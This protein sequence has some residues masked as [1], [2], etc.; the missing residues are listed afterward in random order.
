MTHTSKYINAYLGVL[1]LGAT[2]ILSQFTRYLLREVL[3]KILTAFSKPG[4]VV[5]EQGR[6]QV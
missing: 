2:P 4:S 5:A 1:N 3:D 6:G